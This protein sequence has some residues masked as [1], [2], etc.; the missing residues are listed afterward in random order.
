[1]SVLVVDGGLV[2]RR[3]TYV[4]DI[5]LKVLEAGLNGFNHPLSVIRTLFHRILYL[6]AYFHAVSLPILFAG[7]GFLLASCI[8]TSRID[9]SIAIAAEK[10]EGLIK[11]AEICDPAPSN[12]FRWPKAHKTKDDS[13]ASG[14]SG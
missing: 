8:H 2:W 3:R 4:N 12:L 7:E 9:L 13:S 10:V 5:G 14:L 1:M 6:R 11:L